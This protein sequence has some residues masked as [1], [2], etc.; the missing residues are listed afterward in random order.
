MRAFVFYNSFNSW[1]WLDSFPKE[2]LNLPSDEEVTNPLFYNDTMESVTA[3]LF[4]FITDG[5]DLLEDV[6]EGTAGAELAS[7]LERSKF[8]FTSS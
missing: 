7:A 2:K 3:L 6:T 5:E 4:Q 8:S 1:G